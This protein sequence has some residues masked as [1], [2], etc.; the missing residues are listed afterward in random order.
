MLE[1]A[2]ILEKLRGGAL[3][4]EDVGGIVGEREYFIRQCAIHEVAFM[5]AIAEINPASTIEDRHS[6]KRMFLSRVEQSSEG[7][8]IIEALVASYKRGDR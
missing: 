1:A 3:S 6:I 2:E 7:K 4:L 8:E 5:V